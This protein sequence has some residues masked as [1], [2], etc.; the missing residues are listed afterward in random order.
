MLSRITTN[1][2]Y[3]FFLTIVLTILLAGLGSYGLAETSEARYAEISREMLNSADYLNPKLLGIFHFHKPPIVYYITTLGY[4]I[5]GINEFGARFFLQ[6]AIVLQLIFVY[7]MANLLYK[8]RKIAFMS[9]LVYFAMPIVLISSRNLTT[10]AYLTTFILGSLFC[11]QYYTSK[12]KLLGLYLFYFL[13]AIALLTKGPVA[14]LFILIYIVVYKSIFKRSSKI[15]I[16]HILGISLCLILGSSWYVMVVLGNPGLWDYFIEKQLLSRM[17]YKSFN[18]SKPFWFYIPLIIALVLPWWWIIPHQFKKKG[19][20]ILNMGRED[21][22]LLISMGCLFL[23]FSIFK[24]KMV[25]YILPSFWLVA[26]LIAAQLIKATKAIRSTLN[27]V[28]AA[29]MGCLFTGILALWIIKPDFVQISTG[30]LI[31]SFI[32]LIVL[33]VIYFLVDNLRPEKPAILGA[34]FGAALILISTSLMAHNGPTFNST[35][36]LMGYINN[37]TL[38]THKTV[39]VYDYLL[40][41]IP[42]YSDAHQITLKLK[43]NTTNR[44]IQFQ[45][46]DDW[47]ESLWDINDQVMVSRLDSLSYSPNTYLLIDK[48]RGFKDGLKYLEPH[49]KNRKVYQNWLILFNK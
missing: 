44:E 11:W 4:R 47:K 45:N 3:L 41:S 29:L 35:K 30:T 13:M 42:I 22:L 24:N 21:R 27:M 14:L 34:G 18:R 31:N 46:N 49:F 6:I 33:A 38:K 17:A 2:Y 37:V 12:G 48:K 9:G 5:F 43:H 1:G 36:E 16:H 32:S 39:V 15:N 23:I 10:D 28:Y 25:L 8:D 40:S 19:K 7:G 20:K 26:I